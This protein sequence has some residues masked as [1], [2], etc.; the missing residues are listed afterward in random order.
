MDAERAL[1]LQKRRFVVIVAALSPAATGQ[2][3]AHFEEVSLF[4]SLG[5]G[6]KGV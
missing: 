5:I 4:T 1:R 2:T 3:G 6:E